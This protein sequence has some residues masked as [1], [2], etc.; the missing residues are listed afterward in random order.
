MVE[1]FRI[2]DFQVAR[3]ELA[4]ARRVCDVRRAEAME[5]RVETAEEVLELVKEDLLQLEREM[6]G[7]A[8]ANDNDESP[9]DGMR[10]K[11]QLQLETRFREIEASETPS[12]RHSQGFGNFLA[13]P[14]VDSSLSL[15]R[16]HPPT[17]IQPPWLALGH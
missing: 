15:L 2:C 6:E 8:S 16:L 1:A 9:K 4:A 5:E 7:S 11:L 14:R 3:A 13:P 17:R 12:P 10:E